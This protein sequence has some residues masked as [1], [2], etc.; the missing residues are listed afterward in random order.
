MVRTELAA[1]LRERRARLRPADL[2]L[3]DDGKRRRTP[4]LRRE[5]VAELAGVSHTWYTWLEQ[6]RPIATST[7]VVDALA[8]ALRLTPDEHRHLRTLAGHVAPS[9]D[10]DRDTDTATDTAR[11]RKLVDAA[12]PNLAVI[13]DGHFDYVVWNAAYAQIRHDP[14]TLPPDRLN[15]V[16]MMFTRPSRLTR[17][18]PAARSVLSQFRAAVGR[19]PADLRLVELVTALKNASPEFRDWWSEYP[20]RDFRP[21]TVAVTHP[22][23]GRIGLDL[24]QLRPV[25]YPDLLLVLQVPATPEDLAKV[26][27]VLGAGAT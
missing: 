3:P 2:G 4:G 16:W 15:M 19:R 24:Y 14:A 1:F 18:E 9:P 6:G 7:L 10:S 5:E 21:A 20:V 23:V 12:S 8:R 25:E 22:D 13:Y 17:W 11:L 27:A 26:R